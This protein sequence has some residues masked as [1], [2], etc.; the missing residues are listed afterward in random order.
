MKNNLKNIN[1]ILWILILFSVVFNIIFLMRYN[2]EADS[3][4]YVTLAQEQIRTG[5][6]FPE[7]VFY[8]TGMFIVTPNLLVI[9]FLFVTDNL[10]L[11]RQLAILLL[12]ILIYFILYKVFVVNGER[13][14]I[15]F[16]LASSLFSI[17]YVDA[18][19]VSMHFYQG[20]YVT[21][22]VY[23]LLFLAL[24]NKII[25]S[26]SYM[27]KSFFG[28]LLLYVV[29]N[30]G[31]IRSLL[32]W[33]I[34]GTVAYIIYIYLK[35]GQNFS[36]TKSMLRDQKVL[37]ILLDGIMLAFIVGV[38]V[39]KMFGTGGSMGFMSVLPAKDFGRSLYAIIAG[40]FNLYGNSYEASLFSSG[41]IM[42]FINFFFAVFINLFL[43]LFAIKNIN[44]LHWDSSRFI[45]IFSLVSS[46]FYLTVI[47][48]TGAA[49]VEDRYLIPVYNNNVLL[50]A[51]MGSFILEN[52]LK[53]YFS[54]SLCFVLIYVFLSN[55][56]YLSCQKASFLHQKFGTFAQ[57]VEGITDFLGEN[58]L[59]YGYATFFNAEEYSVLSDNKVRIRGVLF[60]EKEIMPY[61]WLT[62]SR[63]Y[64]PDYF[65]GKTFL[66][67]S[68]AEL[69][70]FFPSGISTLNLGEPVDVLKYKTFSIFVYDYN[71]SS[72]FAKGKKVYYLINGNNSG[73]FISEK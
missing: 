67:I 21:Y 49:I 10:V 65:I 38:V 28:I 66:M 17:L 16:V 25:T 22:V 51:V 58:G 52:H 19:V 43:P 30:L 4:F 71:I 20:A 44:K 34:P 31:E 6:L 69:H 45:V 36:T 42:K 18:S 55:F 24:M 48:L 68:D 72:K 37:R 47:F 61:N 29:A 5:S 59:Q 27:K 26:N 35:N 60:N 14:I 54:V 56:Y 73:M 62:S 70:K 11:A 32:M 7:G 41:G 23:L 50:F 57:G 40:L 2:F 64:E 39:A 3:A 46:F 63:F 12:W 53:K 33:G 15:G 13:D 9:P 1:K 8:S